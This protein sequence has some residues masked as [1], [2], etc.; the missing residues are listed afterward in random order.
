MG[1]DGGDERGGGK[2]ME[3][4]VGGKRGKEGSSGR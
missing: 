3:R 1:R 4:M 2:W